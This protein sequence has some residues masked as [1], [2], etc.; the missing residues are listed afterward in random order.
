MSEPRKPAISLNKARDRA[1]QALST[2]FSE[3]DLSVSEFEARVDRCYG[4]SSL[5]ELEAVFADLPMRPDFTTPSRSTEGTGSGEIVRPSG[6]RSRPTAPVKEHDHVIAVMSGVRRS[7]RWAPPRKLHAMAVMGGV[8]IDLRE[9]V[10][11]GG[12]MTINAVAV[13][14][15]VEIVVPPD[16]RVES[17]GIPLMGGFERLD[18]DPGPGGRSDV[19]VHVRGVAL[20][21]GVDVKVAER[22]ERL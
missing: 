15:G 22:G 21:G 20:M 3:D 6:K 8:E 7:G 18:Q 17:T 13:M 19:V 11:P 1:V 10:F 12:K 16:V 14:G 5:P 2:A 9:A 4:A